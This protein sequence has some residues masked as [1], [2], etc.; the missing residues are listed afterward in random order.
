MCLHIIVV[1]Q[2][3]LA[4]VLDALKIG[5]VVCYVPARGLFVAE[6]VAQSYT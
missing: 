3:S 2:S 1:K 4:D 6:D 5:K